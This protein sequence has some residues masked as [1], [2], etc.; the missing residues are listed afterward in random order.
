MEAKPIFSDQPGVVADY[1]FG[2]SIWRLNL[3]SYARY[4]M[5][6]SDQTSVVYDHL[7]YTLALGFSPSSVNKGSRC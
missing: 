5:L 4:P 7:V 6:A 3:F 1:I 2:I